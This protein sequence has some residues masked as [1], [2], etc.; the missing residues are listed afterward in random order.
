MMSPVLPVIGLY[1]LT[2]RTYYTRD[3]TRNGRSRE[4]GELFPSVL[5][6]LPSFTV[7]SHLQDTK[8]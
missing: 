7:F 6:S 5:M 2:D 8:L 1:L 3:F 4:I